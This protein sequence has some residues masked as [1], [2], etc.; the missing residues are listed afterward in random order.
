MQTALR[1]QDDYLDAFRGRFT[2]L[3]R[4][5][6]LDAFWDNLKKQVDDGW[7]IYHVGD[8][9][10]ETPVYK[11]KL[12]AFIDEVDRLLHTEH[13]EDYCGIVYTDDKE[14]PAYIKIF[15]PNNLGVSCGYS[16]KPPLPG[17]ILSRIPPIELEEALYPAANRRRWWQK[18]FE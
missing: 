17:W 6:D 10:P 7:Y 18:I 5:H 13:E 2:S 4:W 11:D 3:M 12:L 15:D 9:P 1:Q 14:Q 16:E 8:A